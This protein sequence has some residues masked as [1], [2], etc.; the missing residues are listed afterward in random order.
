M[1]KKKRQKSN[2]NTAKMSEMIIEMAADYIDLGKDLSDKQNYLNVAC[3]AWNIAVL[4]EAER[5]R[6]LREFLDNYVAVNPGVDYVDG[7]RDDMEFLIQRKLELFPDVNRLVFSAAIQELD[8]NLRVKLLST[9]PH[10]LKR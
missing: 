1:K 2:R 6:A 3:T 8:G 9:R 4:S 7:L 5:P 10:V